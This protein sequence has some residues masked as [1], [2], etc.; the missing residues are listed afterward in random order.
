[1]MP[2]QTVSRFVEAINRRDLDTAMACYT[3]GARHF[4]RLASYTVAGARVRFDMLITVF[5]DLQ[6]KVLGSRVTGGRVETELEMSGTHTV[7][8]LGKPATNQ[9][10]VWRTVDIAEVEDGLISQRWWSVFDDL[11]LMEQL[12]LVSA[13]VGC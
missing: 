11:T 5:P 7:D 13:L 2:E 1:M 6:L 9:H 8:F 4:T 3:P 12:D 10:V